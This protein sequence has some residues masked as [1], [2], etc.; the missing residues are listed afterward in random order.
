MALKKLHCTGP[1]STISTTSQEK[2]TRLP[3]LIQHLAKQHSSPLRCH[4][5]NDIPSKH[6]DYKWDET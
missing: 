3:V 6:A 1:A 4:P 2:Q 5:L